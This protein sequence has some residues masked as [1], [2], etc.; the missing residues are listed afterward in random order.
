MS[1]VPRDTL[2]VGNLALHALLFGHQIAGKAALQILR[3]RS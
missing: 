2:Q 1:G 3:Q